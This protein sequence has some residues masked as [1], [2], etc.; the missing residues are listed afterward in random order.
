M[1]KKL[2]VYVSIIVAVVVIILG[3]AFGLESFE[4]IK[5][6][7]VFISIFFV[8]ANVL[9]VYLNKH[10]FFDVKKD[11]ES[12]ESELNVNNSIDFSS[13]MSDNVDDEN[14]DNGE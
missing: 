13:D 1:L 2:P 8:V 12:D 6:V 9:Q 7:V 5:R 10:V 3:F 14:S 11:D 4:I